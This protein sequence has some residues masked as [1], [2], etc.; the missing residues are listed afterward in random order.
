[1][2][3][4]RRQRRERRGL[5]KTGA[6]RSASASSS[7]SSFPSGAFSRPRSSGRESAPFSRKSERTHFR[8][9]DFESG[10]CAKRISASF[11]AFTLIELLVVIA[12]ITILASLLLPALNN[13]KARAQG[14]GCLNNLKQ[15]TLAWTMYAHDQEDAVVLNLGDQANEDWTS[16][17]RGV[18]SLDGGPTHSAAVPQDSTN[19]WYLE[20]SPL[21]P[22]GAKPGIW[23]CPSDK[24]TRTLA[25]QRYDRVRSVSMNVM[26][27]IDRYPRPP[28]PWLPWQGRAIK[29]MSDIRNPGPTHCFVF[30][31]EREDSIDAS[32]FLVFPGGLRPPPGPSEPVNPAAYG[33]TDY[34]GSYH[35]GAG[36]LSFADAHA[37]SHKWV[38]PRTRPP[39]VRDTMLPKAFTGG[40]SSP[41]NPDVRWLQERTFQ[42]GD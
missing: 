6:L 33:L 8:C 9:Y 29:R 14:V 13:A 27:G 26:L 28:D 21:A 30:L 39:L 23:R 20:R 18:L 35:N 31:D 7:L 16:W 3:S 40:I 25:G 37:E 11:S 38:D 4:H 12:I 32:F 10:S 42:K 19:R 1:M 22:Y 15:M 24:S 34:P 17:V 2:K 5:R 41:G 36:N